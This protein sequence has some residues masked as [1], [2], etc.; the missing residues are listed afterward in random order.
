MAALWVEGEENEERGRRNIEVK[1][2]SDCSKS[3][4][5][6]YSCYDPLQ[7]PLMFPFGEVGWHQKIPKKKEAERGNRRNVVCMAEKL[8]SPVTAASVE[9]LL[10]MEE[11]GKQTASLFLLCVVYIYHNC[12][13]F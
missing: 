3:V 13:I 4:E 11:N 10:D 8:I 5:Y 2:H 6:Y 9:H 12:I 1:L 7:Y